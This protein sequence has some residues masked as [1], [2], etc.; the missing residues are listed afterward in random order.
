M[1]ATITVFILLAVRRDRA[2]RKKAEEE[3]R[4]FNVSMAAN[5]TSIAEEARSLISRTSGSDMTTAVVTPGVGAPQSPMNMSQS[6]ASNTLFN[7][8]DNSVGAGSTVGMGSL[9]GVP[10]SPQ[11]STVQ[12]SPHSSGGGGEPYLPHLSAVEL[13]TPRSDDEEVLAAVTSVAAG[14]GRGAESAGGGGPMRLMAMEQL[15]REPSHGAHAGRSGST[16][17]GFGAGREESVDREL[18]RK[19]AGVGT[20]THKSSPS[21]MATGGD[22][23]PAGRALSMLEEQHT[24]EGRR[25]P[26]VAALSATNSA[27]VLRSQSDS[28]ASVRR[29]KEA[30]HREMMEMQ[31]DLQEQQLKI[32]SVLGRGGYGTVYHGAPWP[33][34]RGGLPAPPLRLPLR[35]S[36]PPRCLSPASAAPVLHRLPSG[37]VADGDAMDE[38]VLPAC[39]RCE[40]G[41]V[42]LVHRRSGAVCCRAMRSHRR[43]LHASQ[44]CC[45][46]GPRPAGL[47][48]REPSHGRRLPHSASAG[49][50]SCM[51]LS[52]QEARTARAGCAYLAPHLQSMCDAC[53]VPLLLDGY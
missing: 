11:R 51:R 2:L 41:V 10:A 50:D 9:T 49:P 52:P 36:C 35:T 25:P 33:A 31:G 39:S 7:T 37:T 48:R 53:H 38:P 42:E 45:V 1:W 16:N 43:L 13:A 8:A 46:R 26:S 12:R 20:P 21:G 44:Q 23:S 14:S 18:V 47:Q 4:G 17:G 19:A 5:G 34:P 40:A 24:A 30:V 22:E 28:V 3:L 29:M 27:E 32:F 6:R 15:R